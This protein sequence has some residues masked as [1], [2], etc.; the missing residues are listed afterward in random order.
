[1]LFAGDQILLTKPQDDLQYSVHNLK[2]TVE[3]FSMQINTE[4]GGWGGGGLQERKQPEK[5]HCNTL[6]YSIIWDVT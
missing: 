4:E 1:M 3:E 5:R 2:N 6:I